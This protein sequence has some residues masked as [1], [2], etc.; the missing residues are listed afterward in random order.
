[1][2]LRSIG[3]R[4]VSALLRSPAHGL[5][6]G[7]TLLI[8]LRGVRSGRSYTTPVNYIRNGDTLLIVSRR[9]RTW[10][11][12]LRGGA[13]VR[14]VLRGRV[15]RGIALAVTGSDDVGE[16]LRRV[17]AARPSLQRYYHCELATDGQPRDPAALER[18]GRDAV[19]VSVTEIVPR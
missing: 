8:T 9:G 7:S 3:N 4:C 6:S 18:A 14:L 16:G 12:N 13:P 2:G 15:M 19:I 17:L 1:M 10:W 11:R 5:L